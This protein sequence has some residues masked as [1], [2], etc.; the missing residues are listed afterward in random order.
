MF[1]KESDSITFTVTHIVISFSR[2]RDKRTI[3][4]I[5]L[6]G[7]NYALWARAIELYFEGDSTSQWLTDD[8]PVPSSST[9][10]AWKSEYACIRIDLWN[11]IEPQIS[12]PLM[13]LPTAKQVWKQVQ[14]MYLGVNNLRRT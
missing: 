12:G 3:T 9:F 11:C 7:K 13:F 5:L 4:S 6:N 1:A 8:P 10:A 14:E 2:F